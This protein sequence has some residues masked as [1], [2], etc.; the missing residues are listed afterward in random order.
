MQ[1]ELKFVSYYAGKSEAGRPFYTITLSDG[2]RSASVFLQEPI[3]AD[4]LKEGDAVICHFSVSI[5]R[6]NQFEVEFK[7]LEKA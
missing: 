6:K 3:Q 7:G 5:N 1:K 2:T 4:D